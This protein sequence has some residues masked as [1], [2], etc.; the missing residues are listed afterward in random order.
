MV[1]VKAGDMLPVRNR[2][3]VPEVSM[4]RLARTRILTVTLLV[5]LV[6]PAGPAVAKRW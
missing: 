5:L 3:N 2:R 4:Q 6:L 1:P